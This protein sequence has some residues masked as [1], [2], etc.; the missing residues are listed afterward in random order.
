VNKAIEAIDPMNAKKKPP[1]Q[2][3]SAGGRLLPISRGIARYLKFKKRVVA[4]PY[5]AFGSF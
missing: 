1:T 2:M 4:G 3:H 5:W